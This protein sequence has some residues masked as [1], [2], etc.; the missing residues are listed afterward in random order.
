MTYNSLFLVIGAGIRH[1]FE[2]IVCAFCISR[3]TAWNIFCSHA[4][5]ASFFADILQ[6]I[7]EAKALHKMKFHLPEGAAM[8]MLQEARFKSYFDDLSYM[9]REYAAVTGKI[10]PIVMPLIEPIVRD[11]ELKLVSPQLCSPCLAVH[12][13]C[14]GWS[15]PHVALVL[16]LS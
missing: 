16:E 11:L 14:V 15:F 12:H 10:S 4:C 9:L 1:R 2:E 5:V 3:A 8:V 6:L 7:T 13:R